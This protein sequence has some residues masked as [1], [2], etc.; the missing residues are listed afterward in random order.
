MVPLGSRDELRGAGQALSRDTKTMTAPVIDLQAHEPAW[1]A[2]G[3]GVRTPAEGQR[4]ACSPY[5]G[6]LD[7]VGW[8]RREV[9]SLGGIPTFMSVVCGTA[10]RAGAQCASTETSGTCPKVEGEGEHGV[11][12]PSWTHA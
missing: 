9:G 12:P 3:A 1:V 6:G 7:G 8:N 10:E 5:E 4:T 11:V 2:L